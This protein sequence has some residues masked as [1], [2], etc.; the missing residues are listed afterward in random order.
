MRFQEHITEGV[1]K[2][3]SLEPDQF[4]RLVKWN[5]KKYLKLLG[6]N[7]HPLYKGIKIT[8]SYVGIKDV[9]KDRSAIGTSP[10][11]FKYVNKWL[12]KKGW[13]RRDKSVMCTAHKSVAYDFGNA[14]MIF[15]LDSNYSYAWIDSKDFND[16]SYVSDRNKLP[17][18][19]DIG[20]LENLIEYST[21]K[22]RFEIANEYL[23]TFIHVNEGFREAYGNG[24]EIWFDCKQYYYLNLDNMTSGQEKEYIAEFKRVGITI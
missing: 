24:N 2:L 15:P 17:K 12:G 3:D 14:N 7:N 20:T 11:T 9:R 21:K 13:P 16:W 19:W 6:R 4:V 5:C 22:D 8:E 1:S 10:D 18:D 23:E